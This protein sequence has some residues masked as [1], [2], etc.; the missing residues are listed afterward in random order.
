MANAGKI[1]GLRGFASSSNAFPTQLLI[2]NKW[3]NSVSG[4]TF[5]T[6]NPS[7]E[8]VIATVQSAQDADIDKA[9]AAA[10]HAFEK[11]S[12]SKMQ[13]P[14]RRGLLLKLAEIMEKNAEELAVIE[15][16]DNGKAL[17]FANMDVTFSVEI[18]RYFAGW[19]DKKEGKQIPMNGPFLSYT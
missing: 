7:T 8:E 1:N 16:K 4:A 5:D 11:G 14:D 6:I 3:E 2:N 9:V 12:W 10:K 17:M 15:S 13:G 18:L 19:A